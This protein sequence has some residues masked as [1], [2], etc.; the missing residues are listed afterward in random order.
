[1]EPIRAAG[2]VL[3]CDGAAGREVALVHRPDRGDRTLP[4][5]RLKSKEHPLTGAVREVTE[6]TGLRPLDGG[7]RADAGLRARG[8]DHR[9]HARG[10]HQA[11]PPVSQQLS[12]RKGA[13]WV[14]HVRAA[15]APLAAIERHAARE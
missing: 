14:L 9:P 3:W 2:A 8:A 5:G 11:R 12:L 10:A 6:E 1:M 7:G 13:F 15:D 4:K